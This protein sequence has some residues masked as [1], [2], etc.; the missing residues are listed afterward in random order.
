[1]SNFTITIK[2]ENNP[3]APVIVY[4]NIKSVEKIKE[5][6]KNEAQLGND[7]N[8]S[9]ELPPCKPTNQVFYNYDKNP[10]LSDCKPCQKQGFD[11]TTDKA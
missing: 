8:S 9:E 6:I 2:D 1:M 4:N 7:V 10:D 3:D 5:F 11:Y